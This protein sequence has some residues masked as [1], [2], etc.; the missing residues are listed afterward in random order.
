MNFLRSLSALLFLA[1]S[2]ISADVNF[3]EFYE[4]KTMRID[5][6]HIGDAETEFITIDQIYSYGVWA[7]SKTNLV[8]EFNNGRYYAN[9]YDLASNKL[10]FSKGYDSYFG[11]YQSSG[12]AAKGIKRTY[13]ESVLLPLPKNKIKFV[14]NRRNKDN[15][16]IPFFDTEID[17]NDVRIIHDPILDDKV[18]VHKSLFNGSP[19]EKVDVAVLGE[20]YSKEENEKFVKDLQKFTDIFFKQE[21]YKS[22]KEKFN[23]YGILKPSA[24]SGIDEPRAGIFRNTTLDVTFNSMGSER[25]VLTENNK[26]M[27]DL[28]AHVPYDALYIMVNHKRYGGGGIYNL[29]CTFTADNQWQEYLFLHEFGH[30]FAGLADEY[31]TSSTAYND[32]YK[33]GVEPVEPNITALL[34]IKN[35]KWKHLLDKEIEIPTPWEKEEYDK[36]DYAWQERRREMNNKIAELKKTGADASLIK[37]AELEYETAD[38]ERSIKVDAYLL[39]SK[40]KNKTGAFEGAGYSAKG[41][42]RPM[43]DCIMF[44][45]GSKPFCRVCEER[46][47]KVIDF[48]A[49]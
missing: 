15:E 28:A 46:I 21:P 48:Y 12:D 37:Q 10:I 40:F 11:E 47:I 7:G 16:L 4:A 42:Y 6:F 43:L 36:T 35:I 23:V 32:F 30:S 26:A 5:Y 27:R 18:T 1:G 8:D 22:R 45:K 13:H 39:K 3:N 44:S 31:Y 49:Q 9:F 19:H 25:Y 33:K 38:R 41:M 17:P 29:F 34:D 2:V 20:G 14:L 24:E